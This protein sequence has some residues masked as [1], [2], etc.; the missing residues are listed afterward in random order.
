MVDVS[1]AFWWPLLSGGGGT[2]E[3]G[4]KEKAYLQEKGIEG[5]EGSRREFRGDCGH[6]GSG[7]GGFGGREGRGDGMG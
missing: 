2:D 6:I 5:K 3:G 4:R 7:R 1:G